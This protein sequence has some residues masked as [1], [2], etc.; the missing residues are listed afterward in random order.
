MAKRLMITVDVEAQPRRAER[1]HVDRLIWGKYPGGS[2]GIGEMMDIADRHGVKLTMFLDYCEEHLYGEA[3]LD[4]GREIHRRGHDLQL[5]AHLDFLGRQF[6]ADHGIAPETNLNKLDNAQASAA[7]DFLCGCHRQ[8]TGKGPLAFRGGGY[9]YNGAV[10]KAM[11]ERGV[12][13]STSVNVS[14]N[15]QPVVLPRAKQFLWSSGCLEIPVS[16]VAGYR[17]LGY[18]F[19][20]NFNSG[21]F[22]NAEAMTEFLD[23]FYSELGEDAVAV[24]VMHSWSLLKLTDKKYF[25]ETVPAQAEKFDAFLARIAGQVDVVTASDLVWMHACG[26]LSMDPTLDFTHFRPPTPLPQ[27]ESPA[28]PESG[29]PGV[30]EPVRFVP[31][32]PIKE[33]CPICGAEKSR[34]VEMNGRRCPD[35]GSLERQRCFA[36]AYDHAIHQGFDVTGRHVLIFSPSVSELR[37]LQAR[38]IAGK[39]SVDIRPDSKPDII[40]DICAMPQI[41]SGSQGCVF[42]SYLMPNVH[43]MEAALDEIARIL[44]PGGVFFS[45]EMLRVGLPTSETKDESAITGWYGKENFEKYK[46]GSFRVLGED[47]YL[48]ALSKRFDVTRYAATDPITG[49]VTLVNMCSPIVYS[50]KQKNMDQNFFESADKAYVNYKVDHPDATYAQFSVAMQL[51]SINRGV[52]HPTLGTKTLKHEDFW[53]AGKLDFARYLNL[54]NISKNHKVVDYGCGS[55]RLGAHFIRHL[56]PGGYFGLDVTTDFIEFG[57][58]VLGEAFLGEKKPQFGAIEER[59]IAAAAEFGADFVISTACAFQIRPEEK[60]DFIRNIKRLASKPGCIVCFDT[61]IGK[62]GLRYKSSAWVW[63]LEYYRQAMAPLVLLSTHKI[64]QHH[65]FGQDFEGQI[66]VFGHS[67]VQALEVL[68]KQSPATVTR[69]VSAIDASFERLLLDVVHL[70]ANF[71]HDPARLLP[72]TPLNTA[73]RKLIAKDFAEILPS[74]LS[75]WKDLANPALASEAA[76]LPAYERDSIDL[77]VSSDVLDFLADFNGIIANTARVLCPGGYALFRLKRQRLVAGGIPPTIAYMIEPQ[78]VGLSADASLPSMK[79]GRDW[80]LGA[81]A[82]VGLKPRHFE[83][84]SEETGETVEWFVGRKPSQ[85]EAI[86]PVSGTDSKADRPAIFCDICGTDLS[87][88]KKGETACPKC[89]SA[90]RTR[91][92]LKLSERLFQLF[93]P[94]SRPEDRTLLAFAMDSVEERALI[95]NVYGNYKSASLYG[96]YRRGHE[97]GVD[98]RDLSRYGDAS[99]DGVSGILLFDY[100]EEHELALAEIARVLK[101]GGIFFTHIAAYRLSADDQAPPT[102][103]SIIKKR[104]NY[105]EYV[106]DNANMPSINVGRAWFLAA[107]RRVGLEPELVQIVDNPSGERIDWFVGTKGA[108]GGK[109]ATSAEAGMVPPPVH[110]SVPLPSM[111]WLP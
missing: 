106:P 26:K 16:C 100:F 60:I 22:T 55:L 13:L 24:L 57:K 102:T 6:W 20:F 84:L 109:G 86:D 103:T 5:H 61:K 11:A 98:V 37:F 73:Q 14:R 104:P 35:C 28:V 78:S 50:E 58:E 108:G 54:L 82:A 17:K 41:A 107:M 88:L 76:G 85:G 12:M 89:R 47:D 110:Y 3:L 9:R 15:T 8:V 56:E 59:A 46:V 94:G 39:T 65:E 4:A 7:F 19:D 101:P 25:T 72:H 33:E 45:V 36:L 42:A 96:A 38:G 92:V 67:E 83:Y 71:A 81:L 23:V 48:A 29:K 64:S 53:E 40:A 90:P 51:A 49:Q 79:V 31:P 70:D 34:F 105:F 93:P 43:D 75:S 87:G 63:S 10:L 52:L 111:R 2:F 66:L 44:A 32:L 69:P 80:F 21:Y 99:F 1:D 91:T 68:A 95:P 62:E 97:E 18:L 30:P 27:A 74:V 77:F